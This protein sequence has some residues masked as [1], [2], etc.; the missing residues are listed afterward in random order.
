MLPN[1]FL[2]SFI[3]VLFI[4]LAINK[5]TNVGLQ[6]EYTLEKM[7]FFVSIENQLN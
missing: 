1:M 3:V 5:Q 6:K 2:D 7:F 4:V